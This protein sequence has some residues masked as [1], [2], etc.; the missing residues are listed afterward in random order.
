MSI[1]SYPRR[2]NLR[3]WKFA[4]CAF[5]AKSSLISAS[6]S[7]TFRFGAL[8][9]AGSVMG[10]PYTFQTL[11]NILSVADKSKA[12]DILENHRRVNRGLLPVGLK[13][14]CLNSGEGF[15]T[16]VQHLG[17]W[18]SVVE[19]NSY[20]HADASFTLLLHPVGSAEVAIDLVALIGK[21][22]GEKIFGNDNFLVQ[23]CSAGRL[24]PHRAALLGVGFYLGSDKIRRYKLS[25]LTTT[26]SNDFVHSPRGRRLVLY[27]ARAINSFF[28]RAFPYWHRRSSSGELLSQT[29]LPVRDERTDVLIGST[30]ADIRNV[31][32]LA[33]ILFHEQDEAYWAYV[34]KDFQKRMANLLQYHKLSHL[35]DAPWIYATKPESTNDERFFNAFNELMAH[36][37][38]EVSRLTKTKRSTAITWEEW[39]KEGVERRQAPSLL[40]SAQA[41]LRDCREEVEEEC[42]R[43]FVR[44]KEGERL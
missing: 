6:V 15:N 11:L 4:C 14:H 22:T 7:T 32:L 26:F 39:V 36:A 18:E 40:E 16:L 10:I 9:H 1:F 34:G 13:L 35:L 19:V 42:R 20:K 3:T 37:E 27:D 33:T 2:C 30:E 43:M 44:H 12:A 29:E 24:H 21:F 8:S 38:Q 5:Y 28:D 23:I 25:D 31:N 41:L 17:G